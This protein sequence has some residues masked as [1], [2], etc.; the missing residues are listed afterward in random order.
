MRAACGGRE[1][2]A[3]ALPARRFSVTVT[4]FQAHANRALAS[5]RR[6]KRAPLA[7]L[8]ILAVI[9][10]LSITTAGGSAP[11]IQHV[12]VIL[13]EN[14]TFDNVLGQL[15]IQDHRDC[16]AASGGKNATMRNCPA[17][18]IDTTRAPSCSTL[19]GRSTAASPIT[20]SMGA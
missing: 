19:P 2:T 17:G 4:Q 12:V 14:H 15:C 7:I 16:N 3:M 8:L 1:R 6:L 20:P 9:A 18:T 11:P 10:L 5:L 13:Q